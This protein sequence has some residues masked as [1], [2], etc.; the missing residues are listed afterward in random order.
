M[1]IIDSVVVAGITGTVYGRVQHQP[2][3]KIVLTPSPPSDTCQT[4]AAY[5]PLHI[6]P[7]WL[8]GQET[9]H[10]SSIRRLSFRLSS[11]T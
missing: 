5:T 7:G 9:L 11:A 2:R 8:L 1:T 6:L 10:K 3:V 4:I